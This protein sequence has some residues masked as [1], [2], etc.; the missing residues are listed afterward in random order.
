[1]RVLLL[2]ALVMCAQGQ[3]S[4][5]RVGVGITQ[6][7]LSLEEAVQTALKNNLE[8]E[9]EKTAQA[10]AHEAIREA[11]GF[12]DPN[13]R[14][15]PSAETRNTPTSSVLA[16]STG[17]ITESSWV[18]NFYFRQRTPWQGMSFRVDFENSRLAT[19]NPFVGLTPYITPRFTAG[20]TLPLLR[21][22][23]IDPD[24]AQLTIRS[25]QADVSDASF[26]LRVIDVI[27]RVEQSYYDL[28][29]A[30]ADLAV[31]GESVDLAREQLDRTRRMIASGTVAPVE[32][33]AAEAELE[34]RKDTYF[35]ALTQLTAAENAL[36]LLLAAGR[37]EDLWKDEVIPTSGRKA[38]MP[39]AAASDL[40]ELVNSSLGRRVELK[41][42]ELSR[43]INA[44][45]KQ[46]AL[47]QRKVQLNLTAAYVSTG[48]AGAIL[49][50]E[51]PFAS[52]QAV[53]VQRLNDL[54]VAAGLDPITVNL[55]GGA[56][57]ADFVGGYGQSL[58]NLFSGR[59]STF[60]G[61]LTLDWTPRNNAAES[62]LAQTAITERKIGLERRQ[63][64][65][66][67]AA[68]VR[69]ALQAVLTSQQRIAAAE[70][71]AR[72]AREKLDSETRLFQTGESTNFF[73]LTRQNELADSRRRLVLAT[74]EYNKSVARF[75]VALGRTLEEYRIT[76]K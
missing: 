52:S 28:V 17:K 5:P 72:A 15:Q 20:L 22:R 50:T 59:F 76:L 18:Q 7:K 67:I 4:P 24:R 57:P 51:N 35:T 19:N 38:E 58:S 29:A 44:V 73:V 62:A 69:N 25:K 48:L 53:L 42:L 16:S 21:D 2:S 27:A 75:E 46:S 32:L 10:S 43:R 64:E 70:A 12:L 36:K 68:Q 33:A 39:A 63:M 31:E 13:F 41:V 26:A 66:A 49:Q 45:R 40:S 1:M 55:S 61:G 3:I 34:R 9:I 30:R 54:S 47:N 6:R 8:I 11:L 23:T 14:W 74:A 56:V 71:S 60:S 65:Q 37:D